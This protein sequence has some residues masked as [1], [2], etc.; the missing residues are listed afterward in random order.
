MLRKLLPAFVALALLA[1]AAGAH[2]ARLPRGFIGISPQGRL[3]D[4]DFRQIR[5]AGVLNIRLPLF[6][7]VVERDRGRYDWADFDAAVAGA[8]AAGMHILPFAWGTPGWAAAAPEVEPLGSFAARV[9]W[10]RFLRAAVARY[11]RRGEFWA[12]H[13]EL[14]YRPIRR[15]EVWNEPNIVNFSRNPSPGRFAKLMIFSARAIRREDRFARV[16]VGGLFGHPL[17]TPPNVD[18]AVFLERMYG[19]RGVRRSFN[20]V[21]LHPYVSYADQIPPQA[22]RLRRVLRRHGDARKRLYFSEVGWGSDGFESRWERGAFGQARELNRA[23]AMLT[24]IRR[25]WRIGSVE[26]FSWN[27]AATH[28]VFCDSSGLLTGE[29]TAKPSWYSFVRWTGG[30]RDLFPRASLPLVPVERVGG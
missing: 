7:Y 4:E 17:Q 8:A 9:G 23:F 1:P 28:C 22:R 2:G 12:V 13:P 29:G 6:W 25:R 30:E 5:R 21:S 11:G 16:L 27:D 19:R 24:R 15:W 10:M 20:G 3:V 26:W 18:S 14:P